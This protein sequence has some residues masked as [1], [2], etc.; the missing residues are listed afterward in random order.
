MIKKI[1]ATAI[2]GI[3]VL[4]IA[5]C[6]ETKPEDIK[7]VYKNDQ[8]TYVFQYDTEVEANKE[9]ALHFFVYETD[10]KAVYDNKQIYSK[11]EFLLDKEGNIYQPNLDGSKVMFGKYKDNT[12]NFTKEIKF[13][14]IYT[15][16]YKKTKDPI[17]SEEELGFNGW[18]AAAAQA[19][20]YADKK[21][22]ERP[23][24]SKFE[25]KFEKQGWK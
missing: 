20:N 12:I 7:G 15:G 19:K 21:A 5:G 2:C 13:N 17:P 6:G 11:S 9:K 10:P 24:K 22:A 4:T 14:K 3:A 8:A 25:E 18:K 23:K 16:E 1:L